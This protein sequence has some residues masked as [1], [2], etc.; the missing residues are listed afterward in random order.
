[1]LNHT[2]R[3]RERERERERYGKI[4]GW[5]IKGRGRRNKRARSERHGKTDKTI[6]RYRT[7]GERERERER[8]E[9]KE[10]EK[11][12]GRRTRSERTKRSDATGNNR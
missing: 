12:G 7:A 1:M 6:R 10:R 8:E 2:A 11:D 9:W 3:E 5:K 4:P